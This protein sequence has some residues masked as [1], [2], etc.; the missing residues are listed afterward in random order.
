[1]YPN[2]VITDCRFP[3]EIEMLINCLSIIIKITTI[4]V[5]IEMSLAYKLQEPI[6]IQ[7]TLYAETI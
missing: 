3:N 6:I 1:M 4:E 7:F 2:V 5:A